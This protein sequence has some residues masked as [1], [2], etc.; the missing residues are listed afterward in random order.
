MK[1]AAE[2][3][4]GTSISVSE[5]YRKCGYSAESTFFRLFRQYYGMSPKKYRDSH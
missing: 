5:V 4:T 1:K 2:L 3:L